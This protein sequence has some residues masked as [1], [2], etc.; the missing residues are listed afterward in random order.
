M[1]TVALLLFAIHHLRH[2]II[3]TNLIE[4]AGSMLPI[5]RQEIAF[6]FNWKSSNMPSID[7]SSFTPF[8]RKRIFSCDLPYADQSDLLAAITVT[9]NDI[10]EVG[11]APGSLPLPVMMRA[12]PTEPDDHLPPETHALKASISTTPNS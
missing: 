8:Q 4:N 6:M 7:T 12:R 9:S 5:F 2:D 1:Y 3:C 10:F 11:W